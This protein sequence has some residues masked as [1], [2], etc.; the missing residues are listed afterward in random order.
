MVYLHSTICLR[1]LPVLI[2]QVIDRKKCLQTYFGCSFSAFCSS[3]NTGRAFRL[4]FAVLLLWSNFTSMY[5]TWKEKKTNFI[6]NHCLYTWFCRPLLI[7]VILSTIAYTR[8]SV[9]H[10]L[11][12]WFCRPLLIHMILSTIAYTR[13]SIDHCLYMWFSI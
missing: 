1:K 8:D 4:N 11:Y 12:T 5:S 6:V 3:S 13:D 2:K 9:H 10:C 7:H